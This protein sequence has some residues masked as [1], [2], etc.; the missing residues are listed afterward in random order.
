M[1]RLSASN[2]RSSLVTS[3]SPFFFFTSLLLFFKFIIFCLFFIPPA[4]VSAAMRRLSAAN[5]RSSLVLVA[6]PPVD[7]AGGANSGRD[8]EL[9]RIR[10][11]KEG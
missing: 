6:E 5:A 8:S 7:V 10:A 3:P 11:K 9:S 1:R 2:A 4:C